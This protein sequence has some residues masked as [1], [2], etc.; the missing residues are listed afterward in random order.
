M[1]LSAQV[2]A[3]DLRGAILL[4]EDAVV[5]AD[6]KSVDS[7]RK[8]QEYFAAREA[9]RYRRSHPVQE[10][11]EPKLTAAERAILRSASQA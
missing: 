7:Y 8:Q 3:V 1:S 5:V 6:S 11:V 9:A 4:T 10:P 2:Q